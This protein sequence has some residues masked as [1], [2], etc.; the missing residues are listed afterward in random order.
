MIEAE[1]TVHAAQRLQQR[2]IPAF[3]VE[4]L[5]RCGSEVRCGDA[6]RLYFDKAAKKR[7]KQ[8]LGG[9]RALKLVEP[10][11]SVYA[12]ISDNGRLITVAHQ[13]KRCRHH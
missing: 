5:E 6:D 3:I 13:S 12:I 8:Y 1:L 2:A 11:I 9:D 4:L 10:W 7:L